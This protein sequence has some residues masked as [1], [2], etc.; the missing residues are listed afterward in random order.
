MD[1]GRIKGFIDDL[2]PFL[3]VVLG[4]GKDDHQPENTRENAQD[5][6]ED[7]DK[8]IADDAHCEME[9]G[10]KEADTDNGNARPD[11]RKIRAFV[12]E[13]LLGEKQLIFRF[14]T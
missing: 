3:L 10:R 6:G 8:L 12:R 5:D 4:G 2:L 11:P 13:M 9:A 14:W 7:I 1:V